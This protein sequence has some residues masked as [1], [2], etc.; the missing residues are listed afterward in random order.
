MALPLGPLRERGRNTL[1]GSPQSLSFPLL[2]DNEPAVSSPAIPF[3]T[4]HDFPKS[5]EMWHP[6]Y[7]YVLLSGLLPAF[8]LLDHDNLMTHLIGPLKISGLPELTHS[9]NT[10]LTLPGSHPGTSWPLAKDWVLTQDGKG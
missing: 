1:E 4:T 8:D 3:L 6:V 9:N 7:L 2:Q 10:P 5:L